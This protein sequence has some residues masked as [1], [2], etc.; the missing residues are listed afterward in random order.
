MRFG[1]IIAIFT[2]ALLFATAFV[3]CNKEN[4]NETEETA[5]VYYTVTFN[6]AGGEDIE[7]RSVKAGTT[8]TE[9]AEPTRDGYVF[10]GW[11]N[12]T[13]Q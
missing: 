6:S 12:G 11:Y 9:P 7:P 2:A 1:K 8:L 5:P 13:K 10:E 4:A 3:S